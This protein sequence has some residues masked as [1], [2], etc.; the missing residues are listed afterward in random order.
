MSGR[1]VGGVDRGVG[2]GCHV[3]LVLAGVC[4][5]PLSFADL[6]GKPHRQVP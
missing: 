6:T 1:G 2:G 5:S 4:G 3:A